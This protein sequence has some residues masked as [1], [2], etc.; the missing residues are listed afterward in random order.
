MIMASNEDHD[1]PNT[2][3]SL[4]RRAFVANLILLVGYAIALV[5]QVYE[6]NGRDR[7]TIAV[8]LY[9]VA[10]ALLVLSGI[11]ELSVDVL[12]TRSVKHGRYHSSSDGWNRLISFLFISAGI[13]DIVAFVYWQNRQPDIEDIV[14]LVSSYVLLI[15]AV[16]ALCFQVMEIGE[17]LWKEVIVPDKI[18]FFANLAVLVVTVMGVVLRHMNVSDADS[19][20]TAKLEFATLPIWL[21][22]SILYVTSDVIR[23]KKE[24]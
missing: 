12:S 1:N 23:L 7:E 9:F 3:A 24:S 20:M 8:A 6:L 22:S 19:D 5:F 18:D 11:I 21:F 13:L 15:M 10:F 14:L 16:L 4:S 2:E 17:V